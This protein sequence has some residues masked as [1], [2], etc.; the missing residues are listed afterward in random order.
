MKI[1]KIIFILSLILTNNYVIAQSINDTIF[2]N[3]LL[4]QKE[5]VVKNIDDYLI[6]VVIDFDS[7]KT[8]LIFN[9]SRLSKDFFTNRMFEHKSIVLITPDWKFY[10]EVAEEANRMGG[11]IEPATTNIFYQRKYSENKPKADSIRIS[12]N[13]PKVVFTQS[14]KD[15]KT[16]DNIIFYHTESFGSSCCP[17]D[18]SW[19][20]KG[21]LDEFITS[22]EK[23]NNVKLGDI[24]EEIR[25]KEGEHILY[26]TLSNLSTKQKL[27][28]LEE[29]RYWK[30]ID[31]KLED[32]EF[33]PQIFTPNS[34]KK[35]SLK[36]MTE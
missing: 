28:F 11:C 18:P 30:Y 2:K 7:K 34:I 5:D 29:V 24:Y 13:Q 19:E 32:V 17:R 12:G 27:S 36:L 1:R 4:I 10:E 9:D 15:L 23:V 31:R 35:E 20:I 25:G 8:P 6:D 3:V 21:K 22:F 33:E 26:F 16:N 14:L